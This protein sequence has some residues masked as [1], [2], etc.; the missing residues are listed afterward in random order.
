MPGTVY[1]IED[2]AAVRSSVEFLIQCMGLNVASFGTGTAFLDAIGQTDEGCAL[3]DL[4][5]PDMNGLEIQR[6]LTARGITLPVVIITGHGDKTLR[7]K[8]IRQGAAGFLD[9]PYL[10]EDLQDLIKRLVGYDAGED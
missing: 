8:A 2:D 5:L 7:E 10:P 9:K 6:E 4:M 3:I 1:V